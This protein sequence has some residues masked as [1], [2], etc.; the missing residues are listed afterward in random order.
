MTLLISFSRED[1]EEFVKSVMFLSA[2]Q[3]ES[4]YCLYED[5]DNRHVIETKLIHLAKKINLRFKSE[6]CCVRKLNDAIENFY[7][8][9]FS[10]P[11]SLLELC[12]MWSLVNVYKWTKKT[13]Y[14]IIKCKD[15]CHLYE[16]HVLLNWLL[17]R[18]HNKSCEVSIYPLE[19]TLRLDHGNKCPSV[20]K[21]IE[22]RLETISQSLL[23]KSLVKILVL[24][25]VNRSIVNFKD[26]LQQTVNIFFSK[27]A[28]VE[29]YMV[30]DVLPSD[31]IHTLY[32]VLP[33][34]TGSSGGLNI[35]VY[36]AMDPLIRPVSCLVLHASD[37]IQCKYSEILFLFVIHIF[38]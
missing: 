17:P 13:V 11:K 25:K 36:S 18:L 4:L 23:S 5:V 1:T 30:V 29:C 15:L 27:N 37:I 32:D 22:F 21:E 8:M 14:P 12:D 16:K 28:D 24:R 3:Y 19:E 9:V 10:L 7:I 33:Y 20:A 6:V 35:M 38:F 2:E 34:N 26:Y 31:R